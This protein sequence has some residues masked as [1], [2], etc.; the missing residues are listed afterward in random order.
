MNPYEILGI[1]RESDDASVRSAYLELVRR[2]P[3]ERH[4]E[5]FKQIS[6]AY[7]A[8]K[9]EKSRLKYYLFNEETW[10]QSPFEALLNHFLMTEKRRPLA[11][12]EMKEYLRKC[13]IQ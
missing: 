10:I 2:Y 8:L 4:P 13:A 9:D 12:E 6:T 1:K 7:N 11:L 3:P 5:K